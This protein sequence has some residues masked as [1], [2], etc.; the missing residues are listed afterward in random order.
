MPARKRFALVLLTLV[1]C[2]GCD[3]QT[4]SLATTHLRGREAKSFFADTVRLDYT[5]NSGAFLGLGASLPAEW[6]TAVFSV[7]CTFGIMAL[8]IY[9]FLV[10]RSTALQIFALA[11]VC[12][13]G[14]GNLIDRWMCGYVRD[15][16][17][18][19]LGPIRTGIFNVADATL[20]A[21]SLLAFLLHR[22]HR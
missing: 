21:G 18:V 19:G 15:F 5:E 20:M 7:G 16:V 11:L 17:N 14:M 4:K 6:R 10:P 3:Q 9:I 12:A 22:R 13:G 1:A 2:V 8:L